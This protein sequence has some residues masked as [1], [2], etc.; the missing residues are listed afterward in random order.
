[1]SASYLLT[2]RNREEAPLPA[3]ARRGTR[4]CVPLPPPRR[5]E[6]LGVRPHV[7]VARRQQQRAAR[8]REEEGLAGRREGGCGGGLEAYG[9]GLSRLA[10]RSSS[11]AD[12][13]AG[14]ESTPRRDCSPAASC[15]EAGQ[16]R[17][18]V[19]ASSAPTCRDTS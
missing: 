2:A 16:R 4:L 6:R 17:H 14:A 3:G 12:G 19:A 9:L 8:R 7:G 15:T 18:A 1:M 5:Q 13:V 11:R 10:S